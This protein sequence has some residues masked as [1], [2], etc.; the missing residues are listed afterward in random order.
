MSWG[1]GDI[2]SQRGRVA[3]VTGGNGG[4]GL[5]VSRALAANGAHVVIACRNVDKG[6]SARADLRATRPDASVE[7]V[8]LDLSDLASVRRA[9]ALIAARHP[10]LDVLVN[11]AGV[12]A[13]PRRTTVDGFE[14]QLAT[15]HLGHFVLT[16]ILCA[17]LVRAPAARVVSVTSTGRHY[18]RRVDPSDPHLNRRYDPWRAYGQSKLAN[19]HFALE[20]DRRLRASGARARSLVAHPGFVNTDLQANSVRESGGLSQRFFRQAVQRFGMSAD[21]G[22]LPLLRSATDPHADGGQLY[23]PRWVNVGPPERRPLFWRST[24]AGA[25]RTLWTVSE[26]ETG[27]RF[28]VAAIVST[29]GLGPS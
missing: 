2:P 21:E 24:D 5:A 29:A 27:T 18:G 23:T 10:R 9:G 19:L 3:V 25:M 22:A 12:M 8:P 7:I 26:G 11:N 16:A 28:D 1:R 15:N 6:E 20:L 14:M 13:I 17:A 4:I